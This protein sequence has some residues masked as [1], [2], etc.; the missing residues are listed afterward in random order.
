MPLSALERTA[1]RFAKGPKLLRTSERMALYLAWH[2]GL[3]RALRSR[4]MSVDVTWTRFV[5]VW[6]RIGSAASID[7]QWSPAYIRKKLNTKPLP[8]TVDRDW[9]WEVLDANGH[10]VNSF[11]HEIDA[12]DYIRMAERLSGTR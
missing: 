3:F 11:R 2:A 10:T 5:R 7:Y 4:R 9:Q 12:W 6:K 8:W 1:L